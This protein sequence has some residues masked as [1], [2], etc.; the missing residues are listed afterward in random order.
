MA[1]GTSATAPVTENA[2]NNE[3]MSD[4][5]TSFKRL[6]GNSLLAFT[7]KILLLVST[8]AC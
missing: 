7:W 6:N 8:V 4:I 1:A 3:G 5:V 2:A